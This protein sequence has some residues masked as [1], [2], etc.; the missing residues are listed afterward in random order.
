MTSGRWTEVVASGG[1]ASSAGGASRM[2]RQ[3]LEA[4]MAGRWPGRSLHHILTQA[5]SITQSATMP[6]DP[7]YVIAPDAQV[8]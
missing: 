7:R 8:C 3:L 1:L 5:G 4:Y 6:A 2:D